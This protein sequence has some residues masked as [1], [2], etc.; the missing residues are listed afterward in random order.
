VVLEVAGKSE[1]EAEFA[2]VE[3][4]ASICF[5]SLDTQTKSVSFDFIKLDDPLRGLIENKDKLAIH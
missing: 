5:S 4:E 2:I 1:Y 3:S